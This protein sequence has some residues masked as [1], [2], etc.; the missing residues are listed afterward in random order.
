MRFGPSG[1][2]MGLDVAEPARYRANV[3]FWQLR[4]EGIVHRDLKPDHLF[5]SESTDGKRVLRVLDFGLARV[6]P[7]VPKSALEPNALPLD[8]G[9]SVR[10]EGSS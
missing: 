6:M 10:F 9:V 1:V 7:R 4:P 2:R 3:D 8:T 5:I